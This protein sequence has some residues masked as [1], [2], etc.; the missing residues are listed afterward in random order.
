MLK[1][2]FP[3]HSGIADA[4]AFALPR[5]AALSSVLQRMRCGSRSFLQSGLVASLLFVATEPLQ[6]VNYYVASNGN[7]AGPGTQAA[8]WRNLSKVNSTIFN[9]GDVIRF[10][11]GDTWNG[12]LV[13]RRSTTNTNRV[14]VSS[15]NTGVK[16]RIVNNGAGDSAVKIQ[17]SSN[18]TL[19]N[20]SISRD[21]GGGPQAGVLILNNTNGTT[22]SGFTL[23][24]LTVSGVFPQN[25]KAGYGI[26]IV[27][28]REGAIRPRINDVLIEGC[29]ISQTAYFGTWI[30]QTPYEE[31]NPTKNT[32]I[33]V[34]N[35][36]FR[37]CGGSSLLTSFCANVEVTNNQMIN[38]GAFPSGRY[39][40]RGSGYWPIFNNNVRVRNNLFQGAMG[41][42][43]SF[44]MHVDFGNNN[45]LVENNLSK[46]NQGGFVQILGDN[47]NVV[48]RYNISINDGFRR[49]GELT[50]GQE[51]S[52]T[53]HVVR[54]SGYVG[55]DVAE[56]PSKNVFVYN[57]TAYVRADLDDNR[58][59][60]VPG[61]TGVIANNIFC[62]LGQVRPGF[63]TANGIATS[64]NLTNNHWF[65]NDISAAIR[66]GTNPSSGA[67]FFVN[68]GGLSATDYRLQT[69]SPLKTGAANNSTW[70]LAPFQ[71]ST[72]D[73]FGGTLTSPFSK[74]AHEQNN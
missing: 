19:E 71:R 28:D 45:V 8:P 70:F 59:R 36:Q 61:T 18:W 60:V 34:R 13:L 24:N 52:S 58:I 29:D 39:Y 46:D 26:Y 25:G 40:G 20:L 41:W 31:A 57:N 63:D 27:A 30:V 68:A 51:N 16:P 22:H 49:A 37:N 23:R 14:V 32:G 38:S 73:Y 12:Q 15:Y 64:V 69:S 65:G 11:S 4:I 53:S 66:R 56:V 5:F 44:G 9:G 50:H 3:I 74:G 1:Q 67:P 72:V 6:A 55:M 7:D 62:L 17:N 43:D 33:I 21:G 2:L 35:N 47:N 10:R 54:I 42:E 48:Y